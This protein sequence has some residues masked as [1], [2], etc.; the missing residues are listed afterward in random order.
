MTETRSAR[1]EVIVFKIGNFFSLSNNIIYVFSG[2]PGIAPQ[3]SWDRTRMMEMQ[4]LLH[5]LWLQL[6]EINFP[7]RGIQLC[8]CCFHQSRKNLYLKTCR[9]WW[10]QN[11]KHLQLALRRG[12]DIFK[13]LTSYFKF[14]L[15]ANYG[16]FGVCFCFL[17]EMKWNLKGTFH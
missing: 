12:G 7:L 4:Y 1:N 16:L 17:R 11:P 8:F 14:C 13:S 6:G 15:L 5:S 3:R 2:P 10:G 9:G